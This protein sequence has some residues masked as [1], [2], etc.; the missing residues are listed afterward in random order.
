MDALA[1]RHG[2]IAELIGV[3]DVHY[4][5]IP[6]HGN[7]GDLLIMLGTLEFFKRHRIEPK[8]KAGFYNY[9]ARWA[10]ES[11]VI[12]FHGG[13]NLGD[14]Y[15]RPQAKREEIIS[16]LRGNRIIILP[17]T[18]HFSQQE[19]FERALKI[20][21]GHSDLH[22]F[23]RDNL[24]YEIAR[25]MTDN[26]YLAPDMAHNLWR[27]Q[28]FSDHKSST[29]DRLLVF[30]RSDEEIGIEN[31]RDQAAVDWPDIVGKRREAMILWFYRVGKL[32]HLMKLDRFIVGP[33]MKI[34][35]R[36]AWTLT[37]DALA[38][39]NSHDRVVTDRLHGHILSCLLSIRNRVVDNSYGKNFSYLNC[40]TIRSNIVGN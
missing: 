40:W 13:G 19:N 12:V 37:L 6:V 22:I 36:F 28:H 5:D 4:V 26:A 16:Q 7:V 9:S 35:E 10:K 29:A 38:L 15:S 21:R 34:W 2:V 20:F 18:I 17:Q 11:D 27:T 14:I 31:I 33:Q 25:Q 8:I 3:R 24:S 23:A 30:A 39:F 32:L 1:A